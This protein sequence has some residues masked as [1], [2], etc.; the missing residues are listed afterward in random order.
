[1]SGGYSGRFS[2]KFLCALVCAFFAFSIAVNCFESHDVRADGVVECGVNSSEIDSAVIYV[3]SWGFE[4]NVESISLKIVI[5][6]SP[7]DVDYL[8]GSNKYSS[9]LSCSEDV[10]SVTVVPYQW[11]TFLVSCTNKGSD[12]KVEDYSY[13]VTYSAEPTEPDPTTT[14]PTTTEPTTVPTNTP[15][16][17]STPVPTKAPTKAPDPTTAPTQTQQ[18]TQA[19]QATAE[20]DTTTDTSA[21]TSDATTAVTES[22]AQTTTATVATSASVVMAT[23]TP[24]VEET[25]IL[26]EDGDGA[27]DETN[28]DGTPVVAALTATGSGGSKSGPKKSSGASWL[29]I[30]LLIIAG[31]LL[32]LR[33]RY[34]KKKEK[35][36]GSDLA[37]AFIPGVPFLAEKFFGYLGPVK[38]MNTSAPVSEKSFN[39]ANAMKEI[40]AM[41]TSENGIATGTRPAVQKAPVKRPA[42]LS[43]NHSKTVTEAKTAETA[44]AVK[45]A[46][47]AAKTSAPKPSVQNSKK[48]IT[49][50]QFAGREEAKKLL[51]ERRAAQ[52]ARVEQIRKNAE[53]RKAAAAKDGIANAEKKPVQ[54]KP[55]VK[56]PASLSVNHAQAVATGAAVGTAS[57]TADTTAKTDAAA[58]RPGSNKPVEKTEVKPIGKIGVKSE[59]K[60]VDKAVSK[61]AEKPVEKN[62][63]KA[64]AKPVEQ[65]KPA[66]RPGSAAASAG[67]VTAVAGDKKENTTE[68]KEKPMEHNFTSAPQNGPVKRPKAELT[69]EQIAER[70]KAKKLLEERRAAQAARVEEIRKNA[71]AR[72]A[73]VFEQNQLA[74]EARKAEE[75]RRAEEERL[76]REARKAEEAR[77]AEEAAKA[78]EL[79]RQEE[80]RKAEEAAKAAAIAKAKAEAIAEEARRLQERAR[81]AE[82]ERKEAEAKKREEARRLEEARRAEEIRQAQEA[83]RI[84]E[85]RKAEEARLAEAARLE[86]EA[87]AAEEARKAEEARSLA[88]AK[89]AER[90][91]QEAAEAERAAAAAKAQ[92]EAKL[93]EAQRAMEAAAAAREAKAEMNRKQSKTSAFFKTTM[94]SSDNTAMPQISA[95]SAADGYKEHLETKAEN[96]AKADASKEK[97]PYNA[98]KGGIP[99]TSKVPDGA[100]KAAERA[101]ASSNANQLGTILAGQSNN[102]GRPVW[103]A[104]GSNAAPFKESNDARKERIREQQKKIA[105]EKARKE[106]EEER[107]RNP[108]PSYADT[109]KTR[110]SAF[111]DRGYVRPENTNSESEEQSSAYDGIVRP[112]AIIDKERDFR[113]NP[114]APAMGVDVEGNRPPIMDPKAGAA[115]TALKPKPGFK[116]LNPNGSNN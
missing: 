95:I 62:V 96:K 44:T 71:E 35:L 33:Y 41:E 67:S 99:T 70:E 6:C 78:A 103:S 72:K 56:R 79:A 100:A 51:E 92:A 83:R 76:E 104:P 5:S 16:P 53:A 98:Y 22:A 61:P 29:W 109:A 66:Q 63:E 40:K 86:A 21:D 27:A 4:S 23:E 87:R 24:T 107:A 106:A 64:T 28:A 20:A 105:E 85:A 2:L 58:T 82:L 89:A 32:Y 110:K 73:L 3:N 43:V 102:A 30:V 39:T 37:I 77:I 90:A 7:D 15:V 84:E 60:P 112:S 57:K 91:R 1:M 46:S 97:N 10:I 114:T 42:E 47:P 50:D 111:F 74:E 13:S 9:N 75:A 59:E 80:A 68:K 34:L 36:D 115:P 26:D 69:P 38:S 8:W 108:Q 19:T 14:E 101:R 93:A 45:T 12:F 48:E 31:G 17:T 65:S 94:A 52:A 49:A 25:S 113:N 55:P 81:A 11:V 18:E 54:Q 116:P 88:E